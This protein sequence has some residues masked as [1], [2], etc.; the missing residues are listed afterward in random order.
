MPHSTEDERFI[1]QTER[2]TI[3]KLVYQNIQA[4][5]KMYKESI[6]KSRPMGRRV[7]TLEGGLHLAILLHSA[8]LDILEHTR[9]SE[10]PGIKAEIGFGADKARLS[11]AGSKQFLLDSKCLSQQRQ[12][13]FFQKSTVRNQI[14]AKN[15]H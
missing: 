14:G 5:Y 13:N 4:I 1:M 3:C 7:S 15:L 12:F 2:I 6:C 10:I 8:D 9:V 11:S